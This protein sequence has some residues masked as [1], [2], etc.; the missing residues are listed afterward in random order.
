ME[1]DELAKYEVK[2]LTDDAAAR[3]SEQRLALAYAVGLTLSPD[4]TR[5]DEAK[6]L[7]KGKQVDIKVDAH[8]IWPDTDKNV[9]LAIHLDTGNFKFSN[10]VGLESDSLG[11]ND[12]QHEFKIRE[13]TTLL[14]RA[15]NLDNFSPRMVFKSLIKGEITLLQYQRAQ[16]LGNFS[17]RMVF[18][19]P[20]R[21][22]Y[23]IRMFPVSPAAVAAVAGICVHEGKMFAWKNAWMAGR[24]SLPPPLIL[25]G[26]PFR[27][28]PNAP[29]LE[30]LLTAM[31]N[32]F[33]PPRTGAGAGHRAEK[34]T[35]NPGDRHSLNPNK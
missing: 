32:V 12:F 30:E 19:S 11:Q 28:L 18:K 10:G 6:L 3:L 35:R 1:L 5:V 20:M 33:T 27:V 21:K 7:L 23:E 13:E 14:S 24:S 25:P 9:V 31:E 16:N 22:D 2:N 34:P 15:Q 8:T 29:P 26:T 17:L 4:N